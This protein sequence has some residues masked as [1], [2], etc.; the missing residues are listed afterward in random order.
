MGARKPKRDLEIDTDPALQW[1]VWR[2]QRL[3]WAIMGAIILAGFLGLFGDSPMARRTVSDPS[4]KIRVDY[5]WAGRQG[6]EQTV[7]FELHPDNQGRASL[8]LDREYLESSG[9][10]WTSPKPAEE[11]A[12]KDGTTYTFEAEDQ[13]EGLRVSCKLVPR[14]PGRLRARARLDSGPEVRIRQFIYP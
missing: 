8:W 9:L 2:W 10:E 6:A 7:I 5:D 4:R 11:S 12:G 14:S 13:G 1:A 3:A